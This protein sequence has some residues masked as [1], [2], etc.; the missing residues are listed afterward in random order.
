M[1]VF[2][3]TEA[4]AVAIVYS[5]FV[6]MF[7]YKEIDV[8]KLFV[9]AKKSVVIS[10]M[11]MFVIS[12]AKIFSWY[13]TFQR[14]PTIVAQHVLGFATTPFLI[15]I[16]INI[17][18]LFVGMF[19]D[20]SA[21]VLILVP[22]FLPV[23]VEVG[24]SPVHFGVIMIVNLAIG[25][26]TPPF[27]LNLFV[28]SGISNMSMTEVTKGAL[29]FIFVLIAALLVITFVPQLSLFLPEMVYGR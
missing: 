27:G 3:P 12:T 23:L 4:A 16:S 10:S 6:S 29:P 19:L 28:A 17:L 15:L 11:V 9:V 7:I 22:I 13:L 2:T 20:P 1:G 8:K 21:A 24:I 25:M 26:L 18:L 14:I 5:I